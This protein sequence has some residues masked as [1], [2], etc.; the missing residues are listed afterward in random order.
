[1]RSPRSVRAAVY[2][3]VFGL[4][5]AAVSVTLNVLNAP[6]TLSRPAMAAFAGLF[7]SMQ[8]AL[9]YLIWVGKNWARM[10]CAAILG[11]GVLLGIGGPEMD[12]VHHGFVLVNYWIGM[13]V[14]VATLILLFAPASNA[15]FSG[16]TADA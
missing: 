14:S 4:A 10:A 11:M 12:G 5:L 6:E 7:L 2:C 13:G 1:M 15:W 16:R 9:A 8:G 3:L